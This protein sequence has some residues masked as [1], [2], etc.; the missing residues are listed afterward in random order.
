MARPTL[1]DK[2]KQAF[3]GKFEVFKPVVTLTPRQREI[4][5]RDP[6]KYLRKVFEKQG[7]K[8]NGFSITTTAERKARKII[9]SFP[10]GEPAGLI[11]IT[12][13]VIGGRWHSNYY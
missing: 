12:V 13:H 10:T 2:F 11:P 3:T 7:H 6:S 8:V 5:L 4:F 9:D 1:S